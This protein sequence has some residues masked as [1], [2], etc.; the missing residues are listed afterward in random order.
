[1]NEQF[2]EKVDSLHAEILSTLIDF[3]NKKNTF[4]LIKYDKTMEMILVK[5]RDGEWITEYDADIW[6]LADIADCIVA[7][8]ILVDASYMLKY[9]DI[10]DYD[11][12][13]DTLIIKENGKTLSEYDVAWELPC[14]VDKIILNNK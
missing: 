14:Y 12:C 7:K 3:L 2:F 13:N 4:P 9:K 1:M 6:M 5:D 10:L 8:Q 11:E